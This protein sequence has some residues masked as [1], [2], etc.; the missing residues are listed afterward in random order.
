ML[1]EVITPLLEAIAELGLRV[2]PRGGGTGLTG[3]A[4]PVSAGCVMI[5][6]EK[7]NR[8][9]GIEYSPFEEDNA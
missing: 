6:T 5:N 8:I 4:V 2:I 7:L 1:Y 9:H 3:G